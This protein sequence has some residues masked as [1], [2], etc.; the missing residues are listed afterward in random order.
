KKLLDNWEGKNS[1]KVSKDLIISLLKEIINKNLEGLDKY[2]FINHS[3]TWLSDNKWNLW[4][5]DNIKDETS[6][7]DDSKNIPLINNKMFRIQSNFYELEV[8]LNGE[9][10]IFKNAN[11]LKI[12]E[13]DISHFKKFN[14]FIDDSASKSFKD[15][16]ESVLKTRNI[17]DK[18]NYIF[19]YINGIQTDKESI[20]YF[21]FKYNN[22]KKLHIY[23][24]IFK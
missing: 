16:V 24:D 1:S 8:E 22:I 23:N 4:E 7:Y 6:G 5:E 14:N 12:R 18:E 10:V 2:F 21:E 3:I 19:K 11:K 17:D 20:K 13:K 9:K 15:I